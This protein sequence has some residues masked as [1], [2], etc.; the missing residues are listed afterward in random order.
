MHRLPLDQSRC[1]G[2][3]RRPENTRRGG[4]RDS[5][6]CT[7]QDAGRKRSAT[8]ATSRTW[9]RTPVDRRSGKPRR[10]PYRIARWPVALHV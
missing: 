7:Q 9:C 8:N 1:K 6:S 4:D 5:R 3:G 2:G 10:R